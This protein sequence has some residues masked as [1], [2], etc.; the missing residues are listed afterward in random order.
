[1]K[2]DKRGALEEVLVEKLIKKYAKH[3]DEFGRIIVSLVT[4]LIQSSSKLVEADISALENAVKKLHEE[5][6]RKNQRDEGRHVSLAST[7]DTALNKKLEEIKPQSRSSQGQKQDLDLKAQD[8][9]V[10]INA[11]N[12]VEFENEE[13]EKIKMKRTK[14]VQQ[15]QWLD[16]QKREKESKIVQSMHEKRDMYVQKGTRYCSER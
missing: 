9:W 6:C 14:T 1:M 12:I 5:R 2:N 8:E 3:D 7:E 10:L 4:K 13:A 16:S 11:L 15:R